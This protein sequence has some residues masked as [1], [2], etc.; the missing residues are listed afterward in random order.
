VRRLNRRRTA[1]LTDRLKELQDTLDRL[2]AEARLIRAQMEELE[3]RNQV[4][5]LRS[6][7]RRQ[8]A[9]ASITPP[10][11]PGKTPPDR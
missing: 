3:P 10:T 6:L 2:M 9:R 4:R 1:R 5:E 11:R 8:R 7:V